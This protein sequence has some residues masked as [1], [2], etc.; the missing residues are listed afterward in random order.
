M[1]HLNDTQMTKLQYKF[2]AGDD[3]T[4]QG[5]YMG[6]ASGTMGR[7]VQLT[8][9]D[10]EPAYRLYFGLNAGGQKMHKTIP[11]SYLFYF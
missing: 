11:E 5:H 1:F 4:V 7:V 8:A 6:T 9:M 3:L 2:N 10:D